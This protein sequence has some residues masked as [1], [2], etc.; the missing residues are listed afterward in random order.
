MK[1]VILNAVND[2]DLDGS[3]KGYWLFDKN[4]SKTSKSPSMDI[5]VIHN[6]HMPP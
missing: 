6:F 1:C 4:I 5:D 3:K 2:E